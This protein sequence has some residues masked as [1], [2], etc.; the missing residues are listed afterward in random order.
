MEE[1]IDS[2]VD[3]LNDQKGTIGNSFFDKI[4]EIHQTIVLSEI[5]HTIILLENIGHDYPFMDN[6]I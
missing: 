3:I 4:D 5:Q 2:L 1:M 6:I